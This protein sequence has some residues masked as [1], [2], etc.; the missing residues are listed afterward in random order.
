MLFSQHYSS[1]NYISSNLEQ[2]QG[3]MRPD[4]CWDQSRGE[5]I[6]Y[7][8]TQ[9]EQL[10]LLHSYQVSG[11]TD[12]KPPARAPMLPLLH[13]YNSVKLTKAVFF[14]PLCR[15]HGKFTSARS[16]LALCIV[17]RTNKS[18]CQPRGAIARLVALLRTTSLSRERGFLP[19]PPCA[20]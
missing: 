12:P 14:S 10:S 16:P 15:F 19:W 8:P 13:I 3:S 6:S 7:L 18:Q 11:H 20:L 9:D 17:K 2:A 4:L 5:L 1:S